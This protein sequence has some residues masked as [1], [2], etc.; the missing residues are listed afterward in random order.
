MGGERK[1]E[2]GKEAEGEGRREI[3]RE[4]ITQIRVLPPPFHSDNRTR[5]DISP[6]LCIRDCW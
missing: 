3:R 4:S 5:K 2:R 6:I 1:E